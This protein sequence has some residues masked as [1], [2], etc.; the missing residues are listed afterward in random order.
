MSKR[1]ADDKIER[2]KAKIRKLEEKQ[3]RKRIRIID[4]SD[5]EEKSDNE[6]QT[7]EDAAA[8]AD[9]PVGEI[10]E[11]II[12]D[13]ADPEQGPIAPPELDP[14]ILLALGEASEDTPQYGE[15]IHDNLA[16]LWL[17]I[18]RKGLDKEAKQKLMKQFLI[19]NNCSLLHAP[20][21]NPELSAF[22]SEATRSKDKRV[23]AVQ[24]QLGLGITAL[25]KG[26]SLLLE[27]DHDKVQAIKYLSDSS[28]LLCDLHFIETEARKKFVTPGLDRSF[29][30]VI[31]GVDRDEM[32]FGS[33]LPEKIKASKAI[34]KQGLQIK[35]VTAAAPKATSSTSSQPSTS[36]YRGRPQGNWN[37]PSRY[38]SARGGRGA[39]RRTAPAGRPAGR[40]A[41]LQSQSKPSYQSNRQRAPTHQQ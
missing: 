13:H 40:P 15:K 32:L 41:A 12:S 16:R 8:P 22:A 31:Q 10:V 23:E 29:L 24:Q 39:P 20:K 28:R 34:E 6:P 26:L 14:D 3:Y 25:N 37:Y 36:N 33:K 18:L 9:L 11:D 21:L 35:K 7:I 17:P 19:P 27:P 5:S 30:S 1:S 38:P 2:Y 4:S